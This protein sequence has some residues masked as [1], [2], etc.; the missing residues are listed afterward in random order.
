MAS[1]KESVF[2]RKR[3]KLL[4]V[5][6]LVFVIWAGW[7][8]YGQW[9]DLNKTKAEMAELKLLE[10]R[11]FSERAKLERE[12]ILLNNYDYIAEIAREYYFMSKPGEI[13]IISPGE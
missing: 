12:K 13:I 1:S 9:V 6:L 7:T 8:L 4:I 5:I 2:K 11:I 10:E 3:V